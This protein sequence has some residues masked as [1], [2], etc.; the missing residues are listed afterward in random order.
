MPQRAHACGEV[1]KLAAIAAVP[2]PAPFA[3]TQAAAAVAIPCSLSMGLAAVSTLFRRQ[4][5]LLAGPDA[6]QKGRMRRGFRERVLGAFA[7]SDGL[8]RVSYEKQ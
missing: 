7:R 2:R 6:R 5:C 8:L 4:R 3:P 1:Q